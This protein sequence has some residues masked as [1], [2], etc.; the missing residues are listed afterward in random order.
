[1]SITGLAI[2]WVEAITETL[3]DPEACPAGH[4]EPHYPV[5]PRVTISRDHGLYVYH[6]PDDQLGQGSSLGNAHAW[7]ETKGNGDMLSFFSIDA[8]T[9]VM[10]GMSVTYLMPF[11]DLSPQGMPAPDGGKRPDSLTR[12]MPSAA[13]AIHLHPAFQQREF[14]IGDG[15]HILETFFLPRTGMDDPAVAYDA[16]VLTNRTPHPI[17]ITVVASL[18]LRGHTERDLVASYEKSLGCLVVWNRSRPEWVRAFGGAISPKGYWATTNQE[19]AYSPGQT[20]PSRLDETGD[21][22][23]ALQFDL[24]LPPGHRRKLRPT[25]V[26]SNKGRRDALRTFDKAS[27]ND[28][29]LKD[30]IEF[31]SSVLQTAVV[32]MPDDLLTQGVQWAKACLVRPTSRYAIGYAVTNDPGRSTNIVARDTAWYTHGADLVNPG[33]AC[34]MLLTLAQTQRKDGL[35]PEYI[36][37][38]TGRIEDHGFNINDGTPLFIVAAAHHVKATGHMGCLRSLYEPSRRAGELIL[39]QRDRRGLVKCNADGIGPRAICG[40]RNVLENE[41]IT[42]VVTE[43]NAECC[44]ALRALAEMA[45]IDGRTR[46]AR[47]YREEAERL[48]KLINRHLINPS[49][50]LYVLNVDLQGHVFTQATA[51]LVFPLIFDVA[52]PDTAQAVAARLSQSD[53]MTDAGI[54]VLPS[55]NPHYNPSFDAGCLGGVWPGVTWWFAMGASRTNPDMMAASLRRAY[56]HYVSDPKVYNTVPGQFSEWSDGQTLVNRGMRLSPWDS[57]RFLW[58]AIEGVAGVKLDLNGIPLDPRIPSNWQWLRIHNL[59]YRGGSLSYFLTRERDGLH[60]YT[61]NHFSGDT[62]QHHYEEELEVGAKSITTGI[63]TTAFRRGSEVLVCM[64]SS[65]DLPALSPVLAHHS[66]SVGSNYRVWRLTNR[67]QEWRFLGT[68]EGRYLQRVADRVE[69]LGYVLYR[70]IEG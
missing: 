61:T 16:I 37:G 26:F 15:L 43:I 21:L 27:Q 49:N 19:E 65:L 5:S 53:F 32:E 18:A 41:Q 3:D 42:G 17:G 25:V 60:V 36:D 24:T 68:V 58:A 22:T 14:V 9:R 64:G 51:D 70:F 46:D 30:T 7:A 57:P 11:S 2:D 20:L 13:G 48:R 55:E 40:W 4:A 62:M 50:G 10:G 1:M 23:G 56:Y 29:A 6:L 67:D 39:R 63:S 8:G 34:D 69:G 47:H 38:N 66:L 59:P 44:A 31:Y 45:E 35:I 52:E 12:A 33:W 28:R 54:R